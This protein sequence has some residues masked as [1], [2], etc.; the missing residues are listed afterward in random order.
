MD[1]GCSVFKS[2]IY[3]CV[4]VANNIVHSSTAADHG[5]HSFRELARFLYCSL[6]KNRKASLLPLVEQWE[7]YV[8]PNYS[9]FPAID[10]KVFLSGTCV[11]IALKI[12]EPTFADRV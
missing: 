12:L 5:Y 1:D 9:R 4:S 3:V 10:E 11:M 8:T 7:E 2:M 6:Q